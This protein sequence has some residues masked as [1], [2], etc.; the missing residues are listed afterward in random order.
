MRNCTF[1]PVLGSYY[2]RRY[3]LNY[4]FAIIGM[5]NINY[6]YINYIKSIL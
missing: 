5:Y 3:S 1:I 6:A 4:S 2:L